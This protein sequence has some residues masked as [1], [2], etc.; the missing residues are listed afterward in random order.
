M[1][2]LL[3][4]IFFYHSSHFLDCVTYQNHNAFHNLVQTIFY[5]PQFNMKDILSDI[6]EQLS[7]LTLKSRKCYYTILEAKTTSFNKNYFGTYCVQT[8]TCGSIG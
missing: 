5:Y 2:N 6:H 7:P 8:K 3:I 4:H 1:E